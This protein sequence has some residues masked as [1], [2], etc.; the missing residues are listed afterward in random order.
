M[1]EAAFERASFVNR[2]ASLSCSFVSVW[3]VLSLSAFS[4]ESSRAR[5]RPRR[6]RACAAPAP[7]R[8]ARRPS[9]GAGSAAA[10][11]RT[12]P[13][14][15]GFASGAS[16]GPCSIFWAACLAA[17]PSDCEAFCGVASIAW[18]SPLP[19][20]LRALTYGTEGSSRSVRAS[21]SSGRALVMMMRRCALRPGRPVRKGNKG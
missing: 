15:V 21:V 19:T 6:A 7:S 4:Q 18:G 2:F 13:R 5:R 12:R 3:T 10:V 8:G 11:L 20:T 17:A 1:N 9:G 16:R 14:R